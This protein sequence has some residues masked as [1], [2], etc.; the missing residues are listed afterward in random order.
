MSPSH[1][2]GHQSQNRPTIKSYSQK[3]IN[4]DSRLLQRGCLLTLTYPDFV[5]LVEKVNR[6]LKCKIMPLVVGRT[7]QYFQLMSVL[8]SFRIAYR[9]ERKH[10]AFALAL[11]ATPHICVVAT[12]QSKTAVRALRTRNAQHATLTHTQSAC[13]RSCT[14]Y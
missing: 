14:Q 13:A 4:A 3:T 1:I 2:F 5:V 9:S 11:H 12:R 10:R 6:G 8:E 7:K